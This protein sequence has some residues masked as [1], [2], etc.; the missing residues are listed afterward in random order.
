M[1]PHVERSYL[2]TRLQ[3]WGL[4]Y[5]TKEK[6]MLTHVFIAID[7]RTYLIS[8]RGKDVKFLRVDF[9]RWDEGISDRF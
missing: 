5:N 2:E 9:G 3:K 4:V 1:N 7:W 8:S 6:Y